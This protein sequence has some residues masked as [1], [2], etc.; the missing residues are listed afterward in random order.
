MFLSQFLKT[1][2]YDVYN[3]MQSDLPIFI[4]FY[5]LLICLVWKGCTYVKDFFLSIEIIKLDG[6]KTHQRNC[7][8][9]PASNM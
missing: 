3:F 4:F 5:F 7:W 6:F 1:L 9:C 2:D 8:K